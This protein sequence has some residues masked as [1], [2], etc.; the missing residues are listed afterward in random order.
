[1]NYIR[2]KIFGDN[3][4]SVAEVDAQLNRAR[5][6]RT[7]LEQRNTVIDG[8][9]AAAYGVDSADNSDLENEH[10]AN[11]DKLR[12]LELSILA[13][14][15][16]RKNAVLREAAEQYRAERVQ[17]VSDVS[18]L[19]KL[20]P[21]VDKARAAYAELH[22]AE[23]QLRSKIN[24]AQLDM[25]AHF[26]D[27]VAPLGISAAEWNAIK[28]EIDAETADAVRTIAPDVDQARRMFGYQAA[29]QQ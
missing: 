11:S 10:R 23:Q 1:M 28:A 8:E 4:P 22:A 12:R 14:N 29:V 9:L 25:V 21:K 13:L 17:I 20:K 27:H 2:L 24:L 18:Q 26:A 6:E 15:T 3:A 19:D 5:Q 16:E 7:Q